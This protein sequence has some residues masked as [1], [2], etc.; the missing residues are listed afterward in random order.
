VAD[1]GAAGASTG[2]AGTGQES[3]RSTERPDPQN[4]PKL[5]RAG[6]ALVDQVVSA[7]GNFLIVIVAARVLGPSAFGSFAVTYALFVLV[8][9]AARWAV[10]HVVL[11]EAGD[12]STRGHSL[13]AALGAGALV[14]AVAGGVTLLAGVASGGPT[15]D[16]LVVLGAFLP[17]LTTQDVLRHCLIGQD[18]MF[19]ALINDSLWLVAIPPGV[20]V[21]SAMQAATPASTMLA[22][23]GAGLLALLAGCLQA[24]ARP[25]FG[26]GYRWLWEHRSLSG[27]YA[28]EYVLA[29]GSQQAGLIGLAPVAG[30]T[31]VG[32]VRGALTLFGPIAVLASGAMTVLIAESSRSTTDRQALTRRLGQSAVVLALVCSL[33][34]I[35]LLLLPAPVGRAILGRTWTG[36]HG[37]ILVQGVGMALSSGSLVAIVGLRVLR[38]SRQSLRARVLACPANVVFPLVLAAPWQALGFMWGSSLESL[39]SSAVFLWAYKRARLSRRPA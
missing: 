19:R 23:A 20:A 14:G 16:C 6:L 29:N 35:V 25:T 17:A 2:P 27:R 1:E 36:S 31:A 39:T 34:T 8:V 12:R 24:R 13:P 22:W 5:S 38:A 10:G 26:Q 9:G 7:S 28:T 21:V 37:L 4:R 33:W 3:E 15:G 18:Q 11:A 30:I 32:A